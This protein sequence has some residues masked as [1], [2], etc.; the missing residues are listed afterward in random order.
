MQGLSSDSSD[1]EAPIGTLLLAQAGAEDEALAFAIAMLADPTGVTW[2]GPADFNPMDYF[3]DNNGLRK[4]GGLGS[5]RPARRDGKER[6]MYNPDASEGLLRRTRDWRLAFFWHRFLASPPR[7]GHLAWDEF[8]LKFRTPWPL[9]NYVLF[10]T[11]MVCIFPDENDKKRGRKAFPL[12]LKVASALR[13]LALGVPVP[14]LE[15]G[16]GLSP[17]TIQEFLFG[18][19]VLEVDEQGKEYVVALD[20]LPPPQGGWFHWFVKHF[21]VDWIKPPTSAPEIQRHQRLFALCGFP[22]AVSSQDAVHPGAWDNCPSQE[23]YLFTGKEGF[24]TLV[25]NVNVSHTRRIFSMHGPFAGS[26][27]DKTIVRTDPFIQ[28]VR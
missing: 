14:G 12:G 4:Q 21:Q 11:R 9:F 6:R 8:R 7:E 26:K 23:R 28:K 22:G 25:W 18:H 24:P 1:G 3:M 5:A 10:Q 2:D 20:D 15:D 16:S 19:D 17:S 13:Y 27:N